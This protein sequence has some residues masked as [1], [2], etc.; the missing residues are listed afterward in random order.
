MA[1]SRRPVAGSATTNRPARRGQAPWTALLCCLM[2]LPTAA[3]GA[4]EVT[5][6]LLVPG[7]DLVFAGPGLQPPDPTGH[8]AIGIRLPHPSLR[9]DRCESPNLIAGVGTINAL[10]DQLDPQQ[11]TIVARN[12]A[13]YGWLRAAAARDEAVRLT[14]RNDARYLHLDGATLVAPYCMLSLDQGAVPP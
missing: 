7:R 1:T 14:F 10:P 8:F 6:S 12:V 5:A 4:A 13:W 3:A 11:Q 9:A 2:L